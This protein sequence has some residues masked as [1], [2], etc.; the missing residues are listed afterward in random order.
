MNKRTQKLHVND[1]TIITIGRAGENQFRTVFIDISGWADPDSDFRIIY[2]RPDE[3]TY[4]LPLSR[5]GDIL[6]WSPSAYDLEVSGFGKLEIR[7]YA[8]ETIG[9]SATFKVRID[10]SIQTDESTPGT[11]RPD[12]VDDILDKVVIKSIEQTV[13]SNED[14]GTNV[15]TVTLT[16]G[17]TSDFYVKNGSKGNPGEKG[18]QGENGENGYTPVRGIDYWTE[19]DKVEIVKLV[20]AYTK[21]E[22]MTEIEVYVTNEL[23]VLYEIVDPHIADTDNPHKVTAKQ[24][25]TYTNDEIDT[26]RL[27]DKLNMEKY[28]EMRI[29]E[30]FGEI[31]AV[32]DELHAYA[33]SLIGGE[34]E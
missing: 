19:E 3:I 33:Q 8:G 25:G 13:T 12:W 5:K 23:N 24:I 16:D 6:T 30:T 7:A 9:K 1:S 27:E 22:T 28:I 2:S 26:F 32:F 21:E 18:E 14:S 11:A 31:N 10:E 34:V 15:I 17:S 20:D 4:P 29:D